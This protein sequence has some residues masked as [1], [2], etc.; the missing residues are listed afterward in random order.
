MSAV[1]SAGLTKLG[2]NT[3]I[4]MSIKVIGKGFISELCGSFP[5]IGLSVY[6]DY[7]DKTIHKLESGLPQ[8]PIY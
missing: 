5:S 3:A 1:F 6:G 4:K 2:N 7:V 8:I